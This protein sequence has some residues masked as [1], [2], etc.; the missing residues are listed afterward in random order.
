MDFRY[1]DIPDDRALSIL[2]SVV[3]LYTEAAV[4]VSSTAVAKD[5]GHRWSSATIRKAFSELEAAGWLTQTHTSSGR[6]P[7]DLG[8]RVFVERIVRPGAKQAR[9]EPWLESELD[10]R[11]ESLTTLLGNAAALLSRISHSLGMTLLV[12]S[13]A[14]EPED[15]PIKITG[16]DQLLGQPEFEDPQPLKVLIHMLDDAAPIQSY[17]R[18]IDDR[19]GEIGVRIG[20]DNTL[21]ELSSF[22]LVTARIDRSRETAMMGVMGPVRME[23]AP[24]IDALESLIRLLHS[25]SASN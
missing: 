5:L 10:L 13:P 21:S 16:V 14:G 18:D 15:S 12:F 19:P 9:L 4:P 23:Y 20:D 25:G 11:D 8:F 6:I 1:Y 2:E 7:T 3:R 24:I 17:L 22:G